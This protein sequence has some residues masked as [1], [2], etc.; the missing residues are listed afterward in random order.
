MVT[1]SDPVAIVDLEDL[2]A[3]V[4]A[5]S[6]HSLAEKAIEALRG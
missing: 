3:L 1:L 5:K 6:E 4:T 2:M